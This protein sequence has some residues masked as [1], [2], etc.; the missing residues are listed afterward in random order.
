MD[1]SNSMETFLQQ[2]GT[3]EFLTGLVKKL[4]QHKHDSKRGASM[5]GLLDTITISVSTVRRQICNL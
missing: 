2:L 5:R 1:E 3:F 4:K